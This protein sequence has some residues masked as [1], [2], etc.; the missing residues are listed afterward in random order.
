VDPM[1][2]VIAEA[3]RARAV[4]VPVPQCKETEVLVRSECSV[5]STGT[6]TWKHTDA[7]RTGRRV[8]EPGEHVSIAQRFVYSLAKGSVM[9]RRSY[10]KPVPDPDFSEFP[11]D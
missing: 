3:G 8:F 5:I 4:E 2:Q 10:L 6:E 9:L 11:T 7:I 1:K